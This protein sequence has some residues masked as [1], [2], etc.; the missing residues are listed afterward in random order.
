MQVAYNARRIF[1]N[2]YKYAESLMAAAILDLEKPGVRT[3]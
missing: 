2:N 3:R 1:K